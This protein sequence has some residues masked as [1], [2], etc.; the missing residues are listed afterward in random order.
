MVRQEARIKS[1]DANL[2]CEQPSQV[3]HPPLT[4]ELILICLSIV[5]VGSRTVPL[6]I[7]EQQIAK[8]PMKQQVQLHNL[9]SEGK[10][11]P[12]VAGKKKIPLW[13]GLIK[14]KNRQQRKNDLNAAVDTFSM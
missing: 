4:K 12:G 8:A 2:R 5:A 9:Q 3:N 6:A 1:G 11:E 7:S 10:S 13:D 14:Q